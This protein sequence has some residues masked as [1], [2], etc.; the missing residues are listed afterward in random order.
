LPASLPPS[1]NPAESTTAA[2]VPIRPSLSMTSGTPAAGTQTTARSGA[3][4][5]SLTSPKVGLPR[6]GVRC[7]LTRNTSPVKPS[8]SRLRATMSPTEAGLLLAPTRATEVGV[9]KRSRWMVLM[10]VTPVCAAPS[11]MP[12]S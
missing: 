4:G 7:L 1:E 11:F 5:N 6:T 9:K 10:V 3:L 12:A 8:L 2:L